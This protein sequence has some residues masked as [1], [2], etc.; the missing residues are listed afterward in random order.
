VSETS[1]LSPGRVLGLGTEL[2]IA[3]G[4]GLLAGRWLDSKLGTAPWLLVAGA[5]LGGFSAFWNLYR[6]VAAPSASA[7]QGKRDDERSDD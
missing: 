6:Q 3:V 1:G 5:A 2:A 7:G 4:L